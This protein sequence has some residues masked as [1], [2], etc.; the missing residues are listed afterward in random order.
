MTYKTIL[1]HLDHRPRSTER[2]GLACSLADE[3]DAHLVGLFAP[4]GPRLPSYAAAEGGPVLRDLL[5]ERRKEV[6]REVQRRFREVAQRNGGE[7]SEWRTADFDPAAAMRLSA[8]YADL[9]VAGQPEDEEEGELRGLADELAFSAGRPVL[10]VPYA[11]RFAALGKRVLVA[12][13][14]GREAARAVTDALPLLKRAEAVEV[15]AFDPER[16]RRGHGELPG[17]DVGLFLARHGVK[18]TVARQSGARYDVG[19]Q[20]LSRA[21]D[22]GADLIVMGAYGHTRVREMVLGGVTRTML[23][24]MTVPVLMSH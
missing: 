24:A 7:R 22:I 23:E 18:V 15:C 12:W 3:F 1:V 10:F 20:V 6:L 2:L 11:G 16:G 9:V 4:G 17:A 5:E 8:R 21:A 14:A 19:S 13:D